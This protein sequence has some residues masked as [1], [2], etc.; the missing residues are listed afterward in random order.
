M[1]ILYSNYFQRM[2]DTV[3]S[4]DNVECREALSDGQC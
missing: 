1:Q 3:E 4:L 2:R